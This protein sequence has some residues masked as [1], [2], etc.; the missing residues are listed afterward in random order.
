MLVAAERAAAGI[1]DSPN[2]VEYFRDVG[3]GICRITQALRKKAE[4]L[5]FAL[6]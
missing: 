2:L 6:F 3:L 5:A 4:Y 1:M